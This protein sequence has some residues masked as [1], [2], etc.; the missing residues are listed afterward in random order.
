MRIPQFNVQHARVEH[1]EY[2][3]TWLKLGIAQIAFAALTIIAVFIYF[4]WE[5]Y[6]FDYFL[7][8]YI[9]PYGGYFASL[10]IIGQMRERLTKKYKLPPPKLPL[11]PMWSG[12]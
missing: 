9:L 8:L 2:F 11:P 6:N 1:P 4:E 5:N 7:L 12:T 3:K 10:A